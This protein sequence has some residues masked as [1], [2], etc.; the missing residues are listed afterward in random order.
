MTAPTQPNIPSR[1]RSAFG[2]GAEKPSWKER[3]E[4]LKNV[5]PLLRM[6]WQTHRGY[7]TLIVALRLVRALIPLGILWIGKLIIDGVV[8]GIRAYS[9]GAAVDWPHLFKLVAVELGL[10]IF[11]EATARAGS[12]VES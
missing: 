2:P 3:F 8:T 7:A 5:P 6:V 9:A 12:L 10:A 4:A 1:P 11:T